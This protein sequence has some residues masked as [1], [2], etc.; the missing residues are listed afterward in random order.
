MMSSMGSLLQVVAAAMSQC[1]AGRVFEARQ[2]SQ[3]QRSGT[4]LLSG[5]AALPV[6]WRASF[7][8]TPYKSCPQYDRLKLLLHSGKSEI[9][10]L[11][12]ASARPIQ[13]WNDGSIT[14]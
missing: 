1:R 4:D 11:R 6:E 10:W 2:P 8:G 5:G 9:C 7:L 14:L 12:S 13:L 3:H